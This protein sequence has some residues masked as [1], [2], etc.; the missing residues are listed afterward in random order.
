MEDHQHF[1]F[2][3]D[4]YASSDLVG[5]GLP[6]WKEGGS[7][8]R[9]ALEDYARDDERARGYSRVSTPVMAKREVYE[10][11]GHWG[12]YRDSMFA[13]VPDGD[14]E[15]VLRPMSCPHHA[16]VFKA[17]PRSYRQMPVRL[18]EMALLHRDERSGSLNGLSRVRA[19][20]LADAHLFVMEHQVEDEVVRVLEEVK[21]AYAHLGL[22]AARFRLSLRGPSGKFVDDSS[23]WDRAEAALRSALVRAG[24]EFEEAAGEGAFYGPKIDVQVKGAHG[25]EETLS[26]VQVDFHLPERFDLEYVGADGARHRP[27]LVHRSVLSTMERM[28]A[29]LV[30]RH[31]GKL[32][33]WLAPRAVVVLPLNRDCADYAHEVSSS[34]NA[35]EVRAEVVE[36]GSLNSRVR[37]NALVPVVLVVGP[38]E[39]DARAVSV[40]AHGQVVGVKDLDEAL[41][42]LGRAVQER[43]AQLPW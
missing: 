33:L 29:F 36:D 12:N 27:V 38:R 6:L 42:E 5:S 10:R 9:S 15:M 34:L 28:V 14:D 39:R 25:R 11:S 22:E 1:N 37:A 16:L 19:M 4:L 30:E 40:R 23:M 21:D 24:I 41:R 7:L 31:Q 35:A 26:T 8:I 2:E 17:S 20:T 18:S 13:P 32:P 43:S 3:L